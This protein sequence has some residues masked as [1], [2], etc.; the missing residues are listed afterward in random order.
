MLLL[1]AILHPFHADSPSSQQGA[2]SC[3]FGKLCHTLTGQEGCCTW[4]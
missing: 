1:T 2:Q 4:S 3:K